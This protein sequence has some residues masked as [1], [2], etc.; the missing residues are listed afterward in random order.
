MVWTVIEKEI[1]VVLTSPK[2][3]AT[4]AVCAVLILLSI[5][6]GVREHRAFRDSREAAISLHQQ[7]L[8]EVTSWR[9]VRARAFREADPLQ[10]LVS[11]VHNDIGRFS[12]VGSSEEIKLRRSVYSDDPILAVFRMVDLTFIVTFVLSLLAILFTYDAVSGERELGTLRL[13]FANPVPRARYIAGKLIG[14]WLGLATPLAILMIVGILG[15]V[16]TGIQLRSGDWVRIA[17]LML[18]SGLYLTLFVALG[19]A[20]SALSRRSSSAFLVLLASWVILVLI[21]PRASLTTATHLRPAPS[22][23]EIESRHAAFENAAWSRETQQMATTWQERMAQMDGLTEEQRAA[24]EDAN[25]WTWME[26]DDERRRQVEDEINEHAR[27]LHEDL[28]NR[29]AAQAGLAL[30]LGRL[31][32]AAVFQLVA[33]NLAGTDH[34]LKDRTETAMRAYQTDLA[35][36][37]AEKSEGTA[38]SRRIVTRR[39][40]GQHGLSIVDNEVPVDLTEMP[41]YQSPVRSLGAAVGPVIPD[42]GILALL[43]LLCFSI[44]VVGF[45]RSDVR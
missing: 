9:E 22:L 1:R 14:I 11:G 23:A 42:L 15:A 37:I 36:F 19:L 43:G 29:K 4:F 10:V 8:S 41:R 33:M 38:S 18:A 17:L 35:R 13:V 28:R 16:L 30:A 7:G 6:L 45:L 34:G 44:A 3:A 24:F 26:E 20:V 2:F 27:S 39:S 5:A 32:P 21:V 31:S 12:T 25:M 40:G